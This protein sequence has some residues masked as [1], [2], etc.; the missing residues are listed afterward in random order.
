MTSKRALAGLAMVLALLSL[1]AVWSCET[2]TYSPTIVVETPPPP[3]AYPLYY[4]NVSSLALREGPTTQARM[5]SVLTF[6]DDVELLETSGGWGRVHDLRRDLVGWASLKYLQ[7]APA[8]R[9][10]PVYTPKRRPAPA[11]PSPEKPKAM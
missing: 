5:I 7:A 9:P 11:S 1:L 3:P 10:R 2:T 8:S 6:N 4:V